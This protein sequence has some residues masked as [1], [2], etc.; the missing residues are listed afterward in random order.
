MFQGT[1]ARRKKLEELA[2]TIVDEAKKGAG[3][4]PREHSKDTGDATKEE[5]EGPR[6]GARSAVGKMKNL[7][8]LREGV[9]ARGEDESHY[10][11]LYR[12]GKKNGIPLEASYSS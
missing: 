4:N 11:S 10:P 3:K 6:L 1:T 7:R 5:G 8:P 2:K 9:E 12:K